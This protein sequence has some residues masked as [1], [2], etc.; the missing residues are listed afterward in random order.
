MSNILAGLFGAA[1]SA[2]DGQGGVG[3][4][5]PQGILA[6]ALVNAHS[7]ESSR[8]G[9]EDILEGNASGVLPEESAQTKRELG[10]SELK[11]E[12][13]STYE[14]VQPRLLSSGLRVVQP[15]FS[16]VEA[17]QECPEVVSGEAAVG[18]S[19]TPLIGQEDVESERER[20]DLSLKQSQSEGFSAL[21][22]PG[23][24][25]VS[26][27]GIL[28]KDQY[29]EVISPIG[30]IKEAM[31]V[32]VKAAC[33]LDSDDE[34]PALKG[35]LLEFVRDVL[36]D[37]EPQAFPVVLDVIAS[38]PD[39]SVAEGLV[40]PLSAP[41]GEEDLTEEAF[42]SSELVSDFE[43]GGAFDQEVIRSVVRG[44]IDVQERFVEE[45]S[46]RESANLDY[47]SLKPKPQEV[48]EGFRDFIDFSE[49]QGTDFMD[50]DS[51]PSLKSGIMAYAFN[52]SS[53]EGTLL[54]PEGGRVSQWVESSLNLGIYEDT[55]TAL[56][57]EVFNPLIMRTAVH[58]PLEEDD[59]RLR[60]SDVLEALRPSEEIASVERGVLEEPSQVHS[61][62]HAPLEGNDA[63]AHVSGALETLRPSIQD[64]SS[65]GGTLS[66]GVVSQAHAYSNAEMPAVSVPLVG[67]NKGSFSEYGKMETLVVFSKPLESRLTD[68]VDTLS[69][70]EK[71]SA[72]GLTHLVQ[73]QPQGGD[74]VELNAVAVPL[75]AFPKSVQV[76]SLS[77][78]AS[79]VEGDALILSGSSVLSS[80]SLSEAKGAPLVY[81]ANEV[82]AAVK[83]AIT[84]TLEVALPD[85]EILGL[86]STVQPVVTV[87][88]VTDNTR[89]ESQS[90]NPVDGGS[91][92]LPPV[93]KASSRENEVLV[94]ESYDF[95]ST[96][97]ASE[98]LVA[99]KADIL[100]SAPK[101]SEAKSVD[102]SGAGILANELGMASTKPD[103]GGIAPRQ[104]EES[105]T[106]LPMGVEEGDMPDS[107]YVLPKSMDSAVDHEEPIVH[108]EAR[109]L[110]GSTYLKGATPQRSEV[111]TVQQPEKIL[112]SSEEA[113]AVE[114]VDRVEGDVLPKLG[115]KPQAVASA[116]LSRGQNSIPGA[117]EGAKDSPK[118]LLERVLIKG[119]VSP[120][121]LVS[122]AEVAD[123]ERDVDVVSKAGM[124]IAQQPPRMHSRPQRTLERAGVP[125]TSFESQVSAAPI[126]GYVQK[127]INTAP[128]SQAP[129]EDIPHMPAPVEE[130][131]RDASSQNKD[132]M[133]VPQRPQE[134]TGPQPIESFSPKMRS[135]PLPTVPDLNPKLLR[136][137]EQFQRSQRPWAKI[138]LPMGEGEDLMLRMKV[139][140]GHVQI[141]FGTQS[142]PLRDGLERGWSE[143]VTQAASRGIQLDSPEF[144]ARLKMRVSGLEGAT[145]AD[146]SDEGEKPLK[147]FKKKSINTG[148]SVDSSES[149]EDY[150]GVL[151]WA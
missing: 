134:N 26:E 62:E 50:S 141:R 6:G 25:A 19:V 77:A 33:P 124:P 74:P 79:S 86:D 143:L 145:F 119:D 20:T 17:P 42:F 56:K 60:V 13:E 68:R 142:V 149:L 87:T 52:G 14:S 93:L 122:L 2:P 51:G 140:S 8:K 38:K 72:L 83:S 92:V 89:G 88:K 30:G 75:S 9:F 115:A 120:A 118:P 103:T 100:E 5:S 82:I 102:L 45:S 67:V 35:S 132:L 58:T 125:T 53:Q 113:G 69:S 61:N 127:D 147:S 1:P 138:S 23:R 24:S 133:P 3:A 43:L 99:E 59:A 65:E 135:E 41:K 106:M 95:P 136:Q 7:G 54:T 104:V 32:S 28:A 121:E 29:K 47:F 11:S 128:F 151:K 146:S 31:P 36:G 63:R 81:S 70:S 130:E 105:D 73:P 97:Q 107:S 96:I 10:T 64:V 66:S 4:A 110:S 12:S 117:Q 137:L 84:E 44:Q 94:K 80:R 71:V 21:V 49:G 90:V 123:S 39:V 112:V 91:G 18:A 22:A 40:P 116:H 46:A 55:E 126:S 101:V 15:V 131:A 78:Y 37:E 34:A 16:A 109:S 111:A 114:D 57:T 27:G 48:I 144:E 148:H 150:P 85:T 129:S 76:S 108:S 98:V 139:S